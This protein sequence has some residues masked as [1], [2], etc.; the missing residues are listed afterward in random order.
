MPAFCY[1]S[2]HWIIH[3][4]RDFQIFLNFRLKHILIE[5]KEK[6]SNDSGATNQCYWKRLYNV[7]L[8]SGIKYVNKMCSGDQPS[9]KSAS[10]MIKPH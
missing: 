2:E 4:A 9:L 8:F 10:M 3:A 1:R 5:R 6:K 7:H